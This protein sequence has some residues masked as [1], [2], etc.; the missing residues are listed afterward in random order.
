MRAVSVRTER[1]EMEIVT[2]TKP[3]FLGRFDL[4]DADRSRVQRD[5]AARILSDPRVRGRVLDVGAGR[6]SN[7]PAYQPIYEAAETLDA[8]DPDPMVREH[9]YARR[10]WACTLEEATEIP[11]NE[12]DAA[13]AFMVVEH[14][15]DPRAFLEAVHRVL[16]PGGVFFATTPSSHHPFAW[17]VR[18]VQVLGLKRTAA[19]RATKKMNEYPAYYRMNSPRAV[20][21]L[22]RE[23]GFARAEFLRYPCVHWDRY[24]PRALRFVPHAYDRVLGVRYAA[25][26]Q[27]LMMTLEKRAG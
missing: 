23:L 13:I 14:V 15:A 1:A 19:G 20:A 4:L 9:P 24:F 8:L 11:E 26:S 3:E 18:A 10:T 25:L 27:L 21:P 12:Y 22:A 7:V 17:T 16:R 2:R 6:S 5:F